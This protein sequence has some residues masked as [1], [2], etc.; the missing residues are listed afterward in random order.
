MSE[1]E[2]SSTH[3]DAETHDE[4]ASEAQDIIDTIREDTEYQK[5]ENVAEKATILQDRCTSLAEA[6]QDTSIEDL[7]RTMQINEGENMANRPQ[8]NH[9]KEDKNGVIKDDY[10]NEWSAPIQKISRSMAKLQVF[11]VFGELILL[12]KDGIEWRTST[13]RGRTSHVTG[14]YLDTRQR[15]G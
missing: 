6:L 2:R 1:T 8:S 12:Y 4:N 7:E 14:F 15:I 3:A 10:G 13:H 5:A 11:Q 9:F